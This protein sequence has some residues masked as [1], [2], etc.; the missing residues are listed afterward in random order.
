[1][2][3]HSRRIGQVSA[4]AC[5]LAPER[6]GDVIGPIGILVV[7]QH[8]MFAEALEVL[9]AGERGLAMLGV[10]GTGEE[11][12]ELARLT[13]PSVVLLDVDLPGMGGE[14]A[15][16][17]IRQL[18]PPPQVVLIS[19]RSE[20]CSTIGAFEAG[21]SGFV[22]RTHAAE[23]VVDIIRWA[24]AGPATVAGDGIDPVP[25]AVEPSYRSCHEEARLLSQLTGR[26]VEV[27]Q[28]IAN[29]HS[30]NEI[31]ARLCIGVST[32]RGHVK[33]TL[34]KLEVHSKLDAVTS[35]LRH[36]VTRIPQDDATPTLERRSAPAPVT[37]V[38]G[39]MCAFASAAPIEDLRG[40]PEPSPRIRVL[41]VDH[42]R[43]LAIALARLL[44][45]QPDLDL[46]EAVGTGEEAL[47]RTSSR[48]VDV[49][50]MDIDL[51][52]I[53][54]V[55][56]TRRIRKR[57]P[58]TQVIVTTPV[59]PPATVVRAVRA[60]AC[61][62]LPDSRVAEEL[63]E[64]IRRAVRGEMIMPAGSMALVL[65]SLL[66][67]RQARLDAEVLLDQLTGRELSIL[68]W[69]AEG[70]ANAEI[71]RRLFISPSTV[72]THVRDILAKLNAH[73]KLE[74]M[75]LGLRHGLIRIDPIAS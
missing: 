48:A 56:A 46:L 26:E 39:S 55:E 8:R 12:V 65:T 19:T 41:I 16:R 38:V 27:L 11:A 59:P 75:A 4:R 23:S 21:A 68:Q 52:G 61:G 7:S 32:V 66:E 22:P 70:R 62:F 24:A 57:H 13:D 35:A 37:R 74:A 53:D 69:I 36:G 60:G 17:R 5:S 54:G 34:R 30:T 3:V 31:A 71:A 58:A 14:E 40:H 67:S 47:E 18:C 10:A 6:G 9:L 44:Q 43:I 42:R 25:G 28:A 45:R 29:G 33:R 20:P 72:Q 64:A 50:L 1:M 73:S 15:T 2:E 63:A 51:P 49:V